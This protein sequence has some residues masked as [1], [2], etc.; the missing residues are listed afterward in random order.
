MNEREMQG[1]LD[2]AIDALLAGRNEQM[3]EAMKVLLSWFNNNT[4]DLKE[5]YH[6]LTIVA[7]KSQ[8]AQTSEILIFMAVLYAKLTEHHG[9]EELVQK[10]YDLLYAFYHRQK[11]VRCFYP[12]QC[13]SMFVDALDVL[14]E[15][16]KLSYGDASFF[17]EVKDILNSQLN[18]NDRAVLGKMRYLII[19]CGM[20]VNRLNKVLLEEVVGSK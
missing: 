3:N 4:S 11:N 18:P 12:W 20:I 8:H 7:K 10:V 1:V 6:V 15:H 2:G 17:L 13:F 16:E 9:Y 14:N 19:D 5:R